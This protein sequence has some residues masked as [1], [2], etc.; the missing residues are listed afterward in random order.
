[1]GSL[2]TQTFDVEQQQQQRLDIE[3]N[4]NIEISHLVLESPEPPGLWHELIGSIKETVFPHGNKLSKKR[5]RRQHA[6]SVLQGLFP[7]LSWGRNYKASKFKND[8]MAGLTLASLCI[9]Q[10][11]IACFL[12]FI[13]FP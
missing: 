8:L 5:N 10:V 11:C 1:M 2:P 13:Y 6:V 12:Y 7:I 9:P 4:G 3:N